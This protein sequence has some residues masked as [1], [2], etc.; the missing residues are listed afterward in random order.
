MNQPSA[1][2]VKLST[3][4]KRRLQFRLRSLLLLVTVACLSL[5]WIGRKFEL[6]RREHIAAIM[7]PIILS[8]IASLND[9]PWAGEYYCGDGLGVNISLVV[10]PKSGYLYEW[11]G[12]L[13]L[14]DRNYGP[15]ACTDGRLRLV[16]QLPKRESSGGIADELI[17]V[18][19]GPR[20]YLIPADEMVRFCN[21]VNDGSEPRAEIHGL[22]LLRHGDEEKA[23]TGIPVVPDEFK[24]YLLARPIEAEIID[25]GERTDDMTIVVLNRGKQHGLRPQMELHVFDPDEQ[26]DSATLTKVENSRSEA[27]MARPLGDEPPPRIGWKLSTRRFWQTRLE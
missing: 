13:G 2:L 6:W 8:E 18:G 11:R 15:V 16:F 22:Y 19:W 23:V 20:Q 12:C 21:A 4:H 5:G 17:A 27:M 1:E 26:V 14:Y 9:H 7:R 10:A 24:D 25:L 3:P